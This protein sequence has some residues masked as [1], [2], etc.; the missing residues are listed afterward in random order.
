MNRQLEQAIEHFTRY[1]LE[2]LLVENY[3]S[4]AKLNAIREIVK[5]V[6]NNKLYKQIQIEDAFY[7][8]KEVLNED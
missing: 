1:S 6:D 3:N 5:N 7:K 2:N 4:K 8:I